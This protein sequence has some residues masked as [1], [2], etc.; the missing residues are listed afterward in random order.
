M[1]EIAELIIA[2]IGGLAGEVLASKALPRPSSEAANPEWFGFHLTEIRAVGGFV[3]GILVTFGGTDSLSGTDHELKTYLL[4]YGFAAIAALVVLATTLRIKA[5]RRRGPGGT[6]TPSASDIG[7]GQPNQHRAPTASS[8]SG[9][10]GGS[11]I[12]E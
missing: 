8:E 1:P 2:L 10:H 7:D 9:G 3:C 11:A 4:F 12:A 6:S 5:A